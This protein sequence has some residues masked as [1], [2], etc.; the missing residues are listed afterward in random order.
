MLKLGS[1]GTAL[2]RR[3]RCPACRYPNLGINIWCERCRTPLDWQRTA[4]A[5]PAAELP[6]TAAPAS[7]GRA[8]CPSCGAANAAGD[9]Y[10]PYCGA[11]MLPRTTI[12]GRPASPRLRRLRASKVRRIALPRLA[13]PRLALTRLALPRL[14][15]PRLT[16]PRLAVPRFP[17][18][19]WIVAV[20]VCVLLIAPLAYVLFPSSRTAAARHSPARISTT[21]TN[22][23]AATSAQAAAIRGVES[24]TGLH[25]AGSCPAGAAC[26]S[27][28]S[29]TVGQD[30]AAVLFSTAGTPG[31]RQCA[32]YVYRSRGDWHF[33][34]A[35]C[36]LPGQ[37]SPLVGREAT[38]HVPG[39]C[40][41]VRDR[42]SL[43]GGVVACLYDGTRV[44]IDGGP[45]YAD[46][47]IW[48]REKRGWIAH[49]FLK[50]P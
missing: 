7:G 33:L 16:R 42:P 30:A 37:L 8:F 9:R 35:V 22:S 23:A 6:L 44:H 29:Q 17:R 41:N 5:P 14:T 31:G 40:A 27:M 34:D 2:G 10:C 20:V 11:D 15:R 39:S 3:V 24:T 13:L 45:T 50:A 12:I 43:K 25:Y 46:G 26:L 47:R 19:I 49:D 4:A 18:T 48:W 21:S 1:R 38:V 36:G 28:L 32:G